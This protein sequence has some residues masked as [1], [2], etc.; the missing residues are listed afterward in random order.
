MD[1]DAGRRGQG[2][3]LHPASPPPSAGSLGLG[4]AHCVQRWHGGSS[5]VHPRFQRQ[6]ER[7]S[8]QLAQNP[9]KRAWRA[10]AAATVAVT[11]AGGLLVRVTDPDTITSI[12]T[13]L[14][15]S[16][17]TATTV[18]YGD[19]VPASTAGRVTAALVML[20]GLSLLSVTTAAVTNAFVQAAARARGAAHD[21]AILAELT[22][23]R[24]EL[25]PTTS[26]YW[27]QDG[28]PSPPA[29]KAGPADPP[30]PAGAGSWRTRPLTSA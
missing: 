18:G 10:I 4:D 3:D 1:S 2:P 16:L 15:W 26:R 21:D 29:A 27:R 8:A 7:W 24:A 6:L 14:W 20:G 17:Q 30:Y 19:V 9:F 12:G 28:C 23:V 25:C 22:A 11:V 5:Q 13:G